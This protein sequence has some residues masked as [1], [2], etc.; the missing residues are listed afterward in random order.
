VTIAL[1]GARGGSR[2]LPRKNVLPFCGKP[3]VEWAIIQTKCSHLVDEVILTTDDDEIADIGH[4][5]GIEVIRRPDWDDPHLVCI[6]QAWMHALEHMGG[7]VKVDDI[8][9]TILPTAPCVHPDDHDKMIARFI[10]LRKVH[11]KLGVLESRIPKKEMVVYEQLEDGISKCVLFSKKGKYSLQWPGNGVH[12]REWLERVTAVIKNDCQID[13]GAS[14]EAE[15][16]ASSFCGRLN[17]H[18]EGKWYQQFDIDD[19]DD[20]ELCEILMERYILKGRGAEV[21]EEYA[22]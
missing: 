18:V 7:R 9:S 8:V 12:T 4:R 1:I 15:K 19:K 16:A 20:F 6:N 22:R 13:D 5:C 10:E 3:L 2:R 21:Y 17:Y 14:T 11:P